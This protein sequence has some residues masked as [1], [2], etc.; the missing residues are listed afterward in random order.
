MEKTVH[1]D[2]QNEKNEVTDNLI[3]GLK[4]PNKKL[5]INY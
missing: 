1:L 2:H 5:D 3:H 4:D